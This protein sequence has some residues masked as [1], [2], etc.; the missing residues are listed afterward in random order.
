LTF[1]LTL[2]ASAGAGTT[3]A[4]SAEE[5]ASSSGCC[6]VDDL[7]EVAGRT[8]HSKRNFAMSGVSA[9]PW[10]SCKPPPPRPFADASSSNAD[11]TLVTDRMSRQFCL[12]KRNTSRTMSSSDTMS[13]SASRLRGGVSASLLVLGEPTILTFA[14]NAFMSSANLHL[15]DSVSLTQRSCSRCWKKRWPVTTLA[16]HPAEQLRGVAA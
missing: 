14:F 7:A 10:C 15:M 16:P 2:S 9:A 5:S 6:C 13:P 3:S 8:S 11:R 12:W 1:A 4:V